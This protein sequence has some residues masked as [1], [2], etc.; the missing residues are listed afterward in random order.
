MRI[1]IGKWQ[2]IDEGEGD[3]GRRIGE[4]SM[5]AGRGEREYRDKGR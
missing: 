1:R 4:E 5:R 2:R 3:M